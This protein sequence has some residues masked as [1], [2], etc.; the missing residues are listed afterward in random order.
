MFIFQSHLNGRQAA[1]TP[2]LK[3]IGCEVWI[4]AISFLSPSCGAYSGWIVTFDNLYN[5]ANLVSLPDIIYLT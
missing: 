2:S 1:P 3:L 4:N 5:A